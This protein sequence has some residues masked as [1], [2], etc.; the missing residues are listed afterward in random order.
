MTARHSVDGHLAGIGHQPARQTRRD[1]ALERPMILQEPPTAPIADQCADPTTASARDLQV[2]DPLVPPVTVPPGAPQCGHPGRDTV[3]T[4]LTTS[5]L[6]R[7]SHD[8]K[9]SHAPT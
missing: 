6:G 9:H 4:T 2:P 5:R 7:V 1:T 3:E 8:L